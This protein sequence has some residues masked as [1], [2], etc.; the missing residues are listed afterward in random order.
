VVRPFLIV[1]IAGLTAVGCSKSER[2][3]LEPSHSLVTESSAFRLTISDAPATMGMALVLPDVQGERGEVSVVGLRY[4]SL[5]QFAVSG[6]ADVVGSKIT[7]RIKYE[8]RLASCTKEI[9]LLTYRAE[10][11]QL[12]PGPYD[13]DVVHTDESNHT[14]GVIVARRVTVR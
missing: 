12:P 7:V 1:A 2:A 14:S 4:G 6:L 3:P 13:V 9:R 11:L 5:C 10:V 8:E